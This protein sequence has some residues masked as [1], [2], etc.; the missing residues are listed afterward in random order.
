MTEDEYI[1]RIEEFLA[2]LDTWQEE[3]RLA[4]RATVRWQ[5][6]CTHP[7]EPRQFDDVVVR[8][9]CDREVIQALQEHGYRQDPDVLDTWF[10]SALWPLSTMGW[11]DPESY[12]DT[13]AHDG[14]PN[15]LEYFN[16]TSVLCTAREI[17]TLWVSRMVM[18]NLYFTGQDAPYAPGVH[19]PGQRL[20]F[21]DV[22]IHAMI[23]DGEGRKM[24]KSLGNGVDPR[25]IIR[26]KGADA[27]RF[28][29][30]QMT[31]QTQDVRMPV[32]FDELIGANTSPKF[33]LGRRLA[34]KIWNATRF[35]IG[36]LGEEAG[37]MPLP[38][39]AEPTRLIDRWMLSRLAR[40]LAEVET[41]IHKYDFSSCAQQMYDLFWRDLC[42]WYLEGVKPT[43]RED[44]TQQRVLRSALGAI[45]RM[46]HPIMPF[47]TESLHASIEAL[48]VE[49]LEE[50]ELPPS[51]LAATA[52]WP[53][54]P[55]TFLDEAAEAQFARL[56]ELVSIIREVR[57]VQKVH[58]RR[59]IALHVA[60]DAT[61]NL[62]QQAQGVVEVLAGLAKVTRDAA[63][64]EGVTFL[65]GN[66]EHLLADLTDA[67]DV[68]AERD[69]LARQR[70]EVEKRIAGLKGRLN[71][72]GYIEK[73][74]PKLVEETKQQL[75]E[76]QSELGSII[77]SLGKL[78]S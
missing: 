10:S 1:H 43:I 44:A 7:D 15:L 63:C 25:D 31:T 28:T 54:M 73:A 76:S 38:P 53:I 24:S 30:V 70:A 65:F 68:S 71:N 49:P 41:S 69:R 20:P 40:T 13:R 67:I 34:N 62:I 61:M 16:P 64:G 26:S 6:P 78:D 55:D 36:I 48:P 56:Q 33:E 2:Q 52:R 58:D 50:I 14:C 51:D 4:R 11:P 29:L 32:E 47:V 8:S 3:G 17:I 72:K 35:A 75:A 66:A 12:P 42:D 27:M 18:F 9:D 74:P 37:G 45:N 59:L 39:D 46:F 60:D 77:Q 19:A 22:F 5:E 23:Q 57:S 21:R